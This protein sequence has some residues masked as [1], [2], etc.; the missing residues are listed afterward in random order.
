MLLSCQMNYATEIIVLG[1]SAWSYV[2]VCR[3]D[4]RN[5][6]PDAGPRE[7]ALFFFGLVSVE[8]WEGLVEYPHPARSFQLEG[9]AARLEA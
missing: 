2:V 9:N 3:V 1:C 5:V 4:A 7:C 6:S 8:E